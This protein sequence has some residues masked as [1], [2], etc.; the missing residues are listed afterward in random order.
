MKINRENLGER[1]YN[2]RHKLKFTSTGNVIPKLAAKAHT[3]TKKKREMRVYTFD[4]EKIASVPNPN[5]MNRN[6]LEDLLKY[7]PTESWHLT[8]SAFHR[9]SINRLSE[10]SQVYT[11]V[12]AGKLA[13]YGW[14]VEREEKSFIPEINQYFTL[15]PDSAVLFDFFTHPQARGKG[16]YQSSMRQMLHDAARAPNLRQVY[17]SVLADNLASHLAIEKIGFE[18][19]CSLYG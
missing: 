7:E 10:G 6:C 8:A 9:L 17:I 1:L 3:L 2:T 18:Y 15:P 14:L 4:A 16:F 5:L 11:R 12:E 19:N 13:H